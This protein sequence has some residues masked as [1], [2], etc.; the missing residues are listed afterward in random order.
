MSKRE[1]IKTTAREAV[2]YWL[3]RIDECDLSVDWSEAE[4]RCWRCGCERNLERCHIVPDSLGGADEPSNIVLLCKRC[5][6]DGPNVSDK[7]IMWDWIK[8]YKVAFYDTFWMHMGMKEYRFIYGK[9]VKDELE[10]IVN[11]ADNSE[12]I[13][14]EEVIKQT[15]LRLRDSLSVHFG[16]PYFNNATIAGMYRMMLKEIAEM[17]NVEFP[18]KTE[19]PQT[20]KTPWWLE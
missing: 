13:D 8:A 18:V 16:Q 6:A 15:Q 2:E 3:S 5:H 11:A 20:G 19:E 1:A 10:D 12:E 9:S 17:Y 7:E 4:E 14:L